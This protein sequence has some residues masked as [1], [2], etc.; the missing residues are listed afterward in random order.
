M[1]TSVTVDGQIISSIQQGLV[2]LVGIHRDDT[3]ADADKMVAKLLSFR[4][5]DSDA[6]PYTQTAAD[7]N[8]ELLLVSQ[9]T[10]S[11]RT[12]SGRRPDLSRSL[13]S[14]DAALAFNK[15]VDKVKAQ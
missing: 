15:F 3:N 8:A 11:A 14:A 7:T 9:F 5:C 10:L 12:G 4:F 1:A 6:G 13:G 2:C